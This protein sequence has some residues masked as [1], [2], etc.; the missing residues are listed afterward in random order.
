M[1]TNSRPSISVED[2]I[3]II[4]RSTA[5]LEPETVSLVDAGGRILA[6]DIVAGADIPAFDNS[7]MDGYAV[8]AA[9]ITGATRD[10]PARLAVRGE[11]RAGG[12]LLRLDDP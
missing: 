11:V 12:D 2:A 6:E 9:D 4:I 3:D 7:A 1:S 8:R 10:R 5:H